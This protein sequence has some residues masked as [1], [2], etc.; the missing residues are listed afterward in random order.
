MLCR[1]VPGRKQYKLWL[2]GPVAQRIRHLTTNQGIAG[3]S[4]ARVKK[5]SSSTLNI[6]FWMKNYAPP[7][8][9]E[10][11]T[12]RL[13]AER[14]SRL[15]HGGTLVSQLQNNQMRIPINVSGLPLQKYSSS[16][17]I[18]YGLVVRIPGSHPGGPGSIPGNGISFLPKSSDEDGIRTHAGR[19][20]WISSPTP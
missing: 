4:P 12:F 18:R 16:A 10:P 11:P 6:L 13:T 20:H 5:F 2:P 19:A 7:G 17:S 8:G 3:S 14:A 15:R 1:V 9:L